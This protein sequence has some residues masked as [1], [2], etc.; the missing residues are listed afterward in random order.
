MRKCIL[1]EGM[2]THRCLE[3]AVGERLKMLKEKF[4]RFRHTMY[5]G[6]HFL[7]LSTKSLAEFLPSPM[8]YWGKMELGLV[9]LFHL[10]SSKDGEA[11]GP[12]LNLH[13]EAES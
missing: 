13:E 12:F 11:L 2:W 9:F 10:T 6:N 3:R 1:K 7:G 8:R 4:L 5:N